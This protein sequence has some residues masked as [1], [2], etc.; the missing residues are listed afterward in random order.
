MRGFGSGEVEWD[1]STEISRACSITGEY[2]EIREFRAKLG[3]IE[4]R[5]WATFDT[6]EADRE[7]VV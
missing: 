5:C 1:L 7:W 6:L 2:C 3:A 4:K